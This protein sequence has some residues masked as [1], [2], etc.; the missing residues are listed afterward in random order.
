MFSHA[1]LTTILGG[2]CS[3]R[4]H[5]TD[6]ETEGGKDKMLAGVTQ[7]ARGGN[8]IGNQDMAPR[9]LPFITM[10]PR[11]YPLHTK[12]GRAR[13]DLVIFNHARSASSSFILPLTLLFFPPKLSDDGNA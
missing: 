2:K 12:T 8:K 1:L 13:N 6:E 4:T 9:T 11:A 5:F 3:C 10:N 7:L